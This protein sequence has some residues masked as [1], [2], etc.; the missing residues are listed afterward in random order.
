[1]TDQPTFTYNGQD[2]Y[3]S[4]KS[5]DKILEL[6]EAIPEWFDVGSTQGYTNSVQAVFKFPVEGALAQIEALNKILVGIQFL[7]TTA[8]NLKH[9]RDRARDLDEQAFEGEMGEDL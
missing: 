5:L 3:L 6:T 2:D 4:D 8:R 9:E 7:G 1:M